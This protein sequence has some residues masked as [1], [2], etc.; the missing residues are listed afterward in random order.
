MSKVTLAQYL[1]KKKQLNPEIPELDEIEPFDYRVFKQ[2]LSADE[3]ID[4]CIVDLEN[5]HNSIAILKLLKDYKI[6]QLLDAK[7]K[8]I[9]QL[10]NNYFLG[11]YQK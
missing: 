4:K 5:G 2:R 1:A 6:N 8:E 3:L 11:K 10:A 9:V 7:T